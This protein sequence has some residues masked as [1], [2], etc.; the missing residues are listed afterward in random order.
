[1]FWWLSTVVFW[2]ESLSC[3]IA[4][5]VERN[6]RV[7]ATCQLS[8]SNHKRMIVFVLARHPQPQPNAYSRPL[9]ISFNPLAPPLNIDTKVCLLLPSL[10]R[11]I[12]RLLFIPAHHKWPY[13]PW[14]Y[15]FIWLIDWLIDWLS[16]IDWLS[17]QRIDRYFTEQ[18][19]AS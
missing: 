19:F 7:A 12:S 13:T 10:E 14:P 17:L 4:C 15:H 18:S 2:L 8:L 11:Y 1:M 5:A 9:N 6:N 16:N 3:R